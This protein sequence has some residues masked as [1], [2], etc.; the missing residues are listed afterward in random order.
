MSMKLVAKS[1][2]F[3]IIFSF[4]ISLQSS[5]QLNQ[6]D[7]KNLKQGHWIR[8]Y[9]NGVVMYDGFFRDDHPVGEFKRYFDDGNIESILIFSEDGRKAD[10]TLYFPNGEIASK[11]K[12]TDRKKEGK[13]QFFSLDIANYMVS[14]EFYTNDLKNGLSTKFY[15]DH[16]I[17]EQVEWVNG[18]QNGDFLRLYQNGRNWLKSAYLNGKLNGKFD[19]WFEDGT[20]EYSGQYVNNIK[21]GSWIYFNEDGSVRYKVNYSQGIPDNPQMDIDATNFIDSLEKN[22]NKIPD[23]EKTGEIH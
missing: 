14:E 10:A 2:L 21:E 13:W 20:P 19:V 1:A 7:Q 16:K 23:P 4:T 15:A 8:K 3:I 11:G 18:V 22:K 12:Y 5:A 6:T 17:A 9:P